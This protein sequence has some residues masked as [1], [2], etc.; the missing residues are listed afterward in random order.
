MDKKSDIDETIL[1]NIQNQIENL[2]LDIE[3]I[4]H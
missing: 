2:R 3:D 4:K 1:T